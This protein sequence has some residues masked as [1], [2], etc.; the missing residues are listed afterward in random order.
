LS[1]RTI[2]D[3]KR[4]SR[5]EVQDVLQ[6]IDLR[7]VVQRQMREMY[8]RKSMTW[9]A[10]Q[11]LLET[12]EPHACKACEGTGMVTPKVR[13]VGCLHPSGIHRCR[14]RQ[15]YEMMAE[16]EF[17]EELDPE[18]ALIFEF[19]HTVHR[20]AQEA[21]RREYGEKNAPAEVE[22]NLDEALV[23]GAAADNLVDRGKFRYIAEYKTMGSAYET[24]NK[25]KDDHI[26]QNHLYMKGLDVPFVCFLYVH[27]ENSEMK[28][29]PMAFD[30]DV[31]EGILRDK[32]RPIEAA[33]DRGEPPIAD[34]TKYECSECPHGGYCTQKVGTVDRFKRR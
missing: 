16:T 20:I 17:T 27:K 28:Q 29:F 18:L 26:K 8:K 15:Y 1:I 14:T 3:L 4:A 12:Q 6:R 21:L 34:A 30:E 11:H 31:Y 7:S 24:L 32:V 19:G 33:A 23:R 9:E 2:A 25:P 22:V 10:Y 5:D 13:S